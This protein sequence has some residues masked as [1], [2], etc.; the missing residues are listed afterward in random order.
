MPFLLDYLYDIFLLSSLELY[1]RARHGVDARHVSIDLETH[2]ALKTKAGQSL[3]SVCLRALGLLCLA[4]TCCLAWLGLCFALDA[5]G[6]HDLSENSGALVSSAYS[7]LQVCTPEE[8]QPQVARPDSSLPQEAVSGPRL[9]YVVSVESPSP[10]LPSPR[11]W[12]LSHAAR[13]GDR[14]VTDTNTYFFFAPPN[15]IRVKVTGRYEKIKCI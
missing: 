4:R 14:R 1:D 15:G 9:K 10:F 13:R 11:C 12:C 7:S 8:P 3:A 2:S 5:F 6:A